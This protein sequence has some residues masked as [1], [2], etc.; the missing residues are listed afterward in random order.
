MPFILQMLQTLL[1]RFPKT[2]KKFCQGRKICNPIMVRAM[3]TSPQ[4]CITL[5]KVSLSFIVKYT[6]LNKE[7]LK[8]V[9]N[10]LI[11]RI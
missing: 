7:Y 1:A 11:S 8:D 6:F 10:S 5:R 9:V 3:L 4:K 2:L